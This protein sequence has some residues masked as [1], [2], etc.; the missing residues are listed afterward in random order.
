MHPETVGHRAGAQQVGRTALSLLVVNVL[1]G[2]STAPLW[3]VGLS[4]GPIRTGATLAALP[5]FVLPALAATFAVFRTSAVGG[6]ASERGMPEAPRRVAGIW[7]RAWR[8]HFGMSA[9]VGTILAFIVAVALINI[10]VFLG[11][12]AA[13]VTTPLN[14]LVALLT[15]STALH[16][17]ALQVESGVGLPLRKRIQACLAL[18][19][20]RFHRTVL[21]FVALLVAGSMILELPPV[22]VLVTLAPLLWV[23]WFMFRTTLDPV[24]PEG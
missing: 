1:V 13:T 9:I 14:V 8:R 19:V 17:L 12:P 10:G 20:R 5:V 11:S 16:L 21:G 23:A 6:P 15:T 18:S 3:A 2:L 24:I 7:W 22:G 4:A